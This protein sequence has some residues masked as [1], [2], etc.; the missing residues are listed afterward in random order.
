MH[1][2]VPLVEII[3]FDDDDDDDD[4]PTLCKGSIQNVLDSFTLSTVHMP[5]IR[6]E[7]RGKMQTCM[8][9]LNSPGVFYV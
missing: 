2:A 3:G 8:Y 6:R 1:C 5:T 9:C 4:L 7:N